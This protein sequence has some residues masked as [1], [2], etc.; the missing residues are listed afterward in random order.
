M[1]LRILAAHF[2][3]FSQN[4]S[5]R[6]QIKRINNRALRLQTV[7]NLSLNSNRIRV[8]ILHNPPFLSYKILVRTLTEYESHRTRLRTSQNPSLDIYRIRLTTFTKS[9]PE[10]SP[11]FSR[12]CYKMFS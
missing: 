12:D 2:K 1:R 5:Y 6:I 8:A 11:D 7:Q 4:S 3:A 10:F 9:A